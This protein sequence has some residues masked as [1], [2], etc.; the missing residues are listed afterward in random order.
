MDKVHNWHLE[1]I[2]ILDIST[3]QTSTYNHRYAPLLL[4]SGI[5]CIYAIR[6]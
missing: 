6:I 1:E 4:P 3:S 2:N 5:V